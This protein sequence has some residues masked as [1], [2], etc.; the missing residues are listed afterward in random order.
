MS[1]KPLIWFST[2]AD[3]AVESVSSAHDIQTAIRI[4]D[5]LRV[6]GKMDDARQLLDRVEA[7]MAALHRESPEDICMLRSLIDVG[8]S[9]EML[10]EAEQHLPPL[11]IRGINFAWAMARWAGAGFGLRSQ[12]EI[13]ARLA[14]CQA[15]PQLKDDTCQVCGCNC[16]DAGV[17]NKLALA[18]QKCPLG[19]WE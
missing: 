1:C 16:S 15:C 19:K 18:G 11:L 7:R 17:L 6:S 12:S 8:D 13:D 2:T 5:C 10:T 4:V 3:F 14:I 9:S